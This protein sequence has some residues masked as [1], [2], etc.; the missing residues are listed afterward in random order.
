MEKIG[1]MRRVVEIRK[2]RKT[3]YWSLEKYLSR[4]VVKRKIRRNSGDKKN[5]GIED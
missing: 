4:I 3:E 2:I 5:K 1:K